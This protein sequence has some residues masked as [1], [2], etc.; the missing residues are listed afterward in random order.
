MREVEALIVAIAKEHPGLVYTRIVV[1]LSNH[2]HHVARTTP[3]GGLAGLSI[4]RAKK[5]PES[6]GSTPKPS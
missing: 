5:P 1:A 2:E 6:T 4:I 3:S